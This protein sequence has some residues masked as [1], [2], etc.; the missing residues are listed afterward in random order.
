MVLYIGHEQDIILQIDLNVEK[1]K[2]QSQQRKF[3]TTIKKTL[4][5]SPI[6]DG[7]TALPSQI[8]QSTDHAFADTKD[9]SD[10]FNSYLNILMRY[11]ILPKTTTIGLESPMTY[12]S[13][14]A[15]YL[16]AVY[17]ITDD[18]TDTIL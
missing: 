7:V 12:K 4:I 3:L 16:K 5:L 6:G 9:Q 17:N 18:K 2:L 8:M 14:L 15:L 1:S 11:G 10:D 13:Y